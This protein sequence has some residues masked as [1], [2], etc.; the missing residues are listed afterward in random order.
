MMTITQKLS[1][2]LKIKLKD[3]DEIW[4]AV[5]LLNNT[6]LE[7][8]LQLI[9]KTCMLN[10]VVGID[11][12]TDP[13]ALS[14]LLSLKGKRSITAK[15]LTEDFFHPKVYIIKSDRQ[16][17]AF[18]G[19]ANCTNGGLQ[20][21]IEMSIGTEDSN[22]CKELVEWFE[23]TLLPASQPLTT[24][25]IKDYKPK[26][27]SRIKRRKKEQEEIGN[28]KEKEQIKLQ[29][30]LKLKAKFISQLKRFRKT[31]E[32][33]EHRKHRQNIVHDLRKCLDYP[34]FKKLDLKT[35]FSIK[36]LGTIVAIKVKRKILT[37]P[38][39]FSDLMKYVCN[40]SIPIK[41]RIDEALT[42]K[43]SIEN[44]GK[45]FISK[46]LVAH[47]SKKY[48]LHNDAFIERLQRPFGLELPR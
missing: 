27:D 17:T 46:V 31:N 7:F 11:L 43:L 12:P 1:A 36:E 22:V 3:A 5:G 30:N 13:Q 14:K 37:N 15:I 38:K 16:M 34:N 41:E 21:N 47:N 48:Y 10:F 28:L 4:V 24:D 45:G 25:F 8:I 2:N 6:G 35:F 26:Y 18:V 32:Y 44:V 39:K 20:D 42:G 33:L 23:K 40:D 29:A 19:S 9:P